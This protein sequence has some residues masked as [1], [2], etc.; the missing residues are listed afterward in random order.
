[1]ER[2]LVPRKRTI[3]GET[4]SKISEIYNTFEYLYTESPADIREIFGILQFCSFH[5]QTFPPSSSSANFNTFSRTLMKLNNYSRENI[6]NG[7]SPSFLSVH[8]H[9]EIDDTTASANYYRYYYYRH[10]HV[11][12]TSCYLHNLLFDRNIY[13]YI[14]YRQTFNRHNRYNDHRA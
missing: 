1:M 14:I 5:A 12:C 4:R 3:I 8:T 11:I 7:D 6:R 2:T 13:R 10:H 9:V